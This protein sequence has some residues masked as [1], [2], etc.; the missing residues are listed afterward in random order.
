MKT[1]ADEFRG[2]AETASISTPDM[3][4]LYQY[5][6]PGT[7]PVPDGSAEIPVNWNALWIA[8][9]VLAVLAASLWLVL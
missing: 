3:D 7:E 5:L 4:R 9:G 8:L 6:D 2:L 1:I